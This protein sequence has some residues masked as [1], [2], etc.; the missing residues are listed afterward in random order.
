MEAE[1]T[2]IMLHIG[3]VR[4]KKIEI[5]A[6]YCGDSLDE[7]VRLAILNRLEEVEMAMGEEE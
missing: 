2:H 4:L 6:K 1:L 5:A 3:P 7:F